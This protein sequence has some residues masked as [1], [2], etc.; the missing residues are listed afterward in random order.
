M[1]RALIV[2]TLLSTMRS[3]DDPVTPPVPNTLWERVET[4]SAVSKTRACSVL[5]PCP[6]LAARQP[7]SLVEK[8]PDR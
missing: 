6:G 3:M 7:P 8:T 4:G 2:R 5:M 1:N